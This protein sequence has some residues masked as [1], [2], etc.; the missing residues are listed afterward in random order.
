MTTTTKTLSL[1]SFP[2]RATAIEALHRKAGLAVELE[3]GPVGM[4]V[5]G[6]SKATVLAS[7]RSLLASARAKDAKASI[8]SIDFERDE[9]PETCWVAVVSFD[10]ETFGA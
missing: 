8:E 5:Y 4:V 10:W 7:A 9:L 2:A 3:P 1:G 6:P